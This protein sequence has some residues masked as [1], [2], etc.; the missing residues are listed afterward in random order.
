MAGAYTLARLEYAHAQEHKYMSTAHAC[1]KDNAG[2]RA[3]SVT[4]IVGQ[5][6]RHLMLHHR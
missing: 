5:V 2:D 4:S 3:D 6:L 1:M